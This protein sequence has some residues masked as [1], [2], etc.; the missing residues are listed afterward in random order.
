MEFAGKNVIPVKKTKDFM[1]LEKWNMSQAHPACCLIVGGVWF[2]SVVTQ[3]T[4]I[5]KGID[6]IFLKIL[7]KKN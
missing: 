1:V 4:L 7:N 6:V 3:F 5:A 2:L